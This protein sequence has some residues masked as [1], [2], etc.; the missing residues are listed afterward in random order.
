MTSLIHKHPL[1]EQ[2]LLDIWLYSYE[3]WGETQADKYVDELE[4]VIK[5]IAANPFSYKERE[6]FSPP[7]RI[8]HHARHLI[9]YTVSNTSLSIIRIL[10][11]RMDI[12]AHLLD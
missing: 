6:E 7:I 10:H 1:A 11:N 9:I 8:C 2:D 4:S 5:S 12:D 3:N